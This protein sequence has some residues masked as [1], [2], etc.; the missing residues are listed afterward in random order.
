MTLTTKE[1][2]DWMEV[3]SKQG[4]KSYTDDRAHELTKLVMKHKCLVD[5]S[6]HARS[7]EHAKEFHY[8]WNQSI[9]YAWRTLM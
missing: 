2:K 1:L 4:T 8:A 5:Y 3:M 9:P 6:G 7:P